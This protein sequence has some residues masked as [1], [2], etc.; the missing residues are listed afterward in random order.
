[1]DVRWLK[2]SR[3]PLSARVKMSKQ[4]DRRCG[5]RSPKSTC[6]LMNASSKVVHGIDAHRPDRI[7]CKTTTSKNGYDRVKSQANGGQAG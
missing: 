3:L 7:R 6:K 4:N 1:M 5:V 2:L